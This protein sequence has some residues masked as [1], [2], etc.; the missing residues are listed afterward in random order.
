[1]K[2]GHEAHSRGSCEDDRR[3]YQECAGEVSCPLPAP[4]LLWVVLSAVNKPTLPNI[5]TR[6]SDIFG[7][8][9]SRD[10]GERV[11]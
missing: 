1:M 10:T 3:W 9:S 11:T 2:P 7:G 8:S 4:A 6:L 5:Y